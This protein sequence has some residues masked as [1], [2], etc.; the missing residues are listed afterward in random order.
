MK[1]KILALMIVIALAISSA[2]AAPLIQ[3][4]PSVSYEKQVWDGENVVLPGEEL[5]F[6]DF[7]VGADLRVNLGLMQLAAFADCGMPF[8]DEIEAITMSGG[9]SL[10]T[11]I[12][13]AFLDVFAGAGAHV[14]VVHDLESK[15]WVFNGNKFESFGDFMK[16][17]SLFYRGGATINIGMLGVSVFADV[18]TSGTFSSDFSFKPI[19]EGTKVSA[20]LL[21]NIG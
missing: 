11:V 20:S 19:F 9:V 8:G 15:S 7:G 4:G 6:A 21:L 3:L 14:E 12:S 17:C 2:F 5:S 10:N 18:P 1:K 16:T 13:L